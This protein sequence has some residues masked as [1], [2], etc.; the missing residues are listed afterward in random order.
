ME[1]ASQLGGTSGPLQPWYPEEERI[2]TELSNTCSVAKE[3]FRAIYTKQKSLQAKFRL[4]AIVVGSISGACSVGSSVFPASH[5]ELVSISVGAASIF[6][7]I[8]N[9]IE[10]YLQVAQRLSQALSASQA[11]NK[12]MIDIRRELQLPVRDRQTS[13]V[14]F[15]RDCFTR[16]SQ[17]L[18]QSPSIDREDIRSHYRLLKH[19]AVG[20]PDVFA[21]TKM[22]YPID[23]PTGDPQKQ[24][25]L[26]NDDVLLTPDSTMEVTPLTQWTAMPITE[27]ATRP[28]HISVEVRHQ[29]SP[30]PK[31]KPA[32][33]RTQQDDADSCPPIEDEHEKRA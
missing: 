28:S 19:N 21:I 29:E 12:L 3:L 1:T 31:L 4:P 18:E 26:P 9:T 22:Q 15:V 33:V 2:L 30:P 27:Q 5:R 6:I 10:S 14:V 17:I 13:G 24:E 20:V 23:R 16:F 8:L 32:P 25:A 11:L 7:A